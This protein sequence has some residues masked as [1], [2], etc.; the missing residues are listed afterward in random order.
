MGADGGA[1]E[2]LSPHQP[3]DEPNQGARDQ[4]PLR[5]PIAVE[6][7]TGMAPPHQLTIGKR[8]RGGRLVA[9]IPGPQQSITTLLAIQ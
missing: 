2:L 8:E 3:V 6:I 9:I 5:Y 1:V 4:E 7:L